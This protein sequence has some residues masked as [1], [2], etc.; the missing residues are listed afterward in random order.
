MSLVYFLRLCVHSEQH[1]SYHIVYSKL[2]AQLQEND[3]KSRSC[4]IS[5]TEGNAQAVCTAARLEVAVVLA[6]TCLDLLDIQRH[7]SYTMRTKM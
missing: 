3:I 5:S 1:H 6:K 2:L 7:R 4:K